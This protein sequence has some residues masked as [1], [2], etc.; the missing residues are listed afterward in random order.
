[1]SQPVIFLPTDILVH[2]IQHLVKAPKRSML[3]AM[4]CSQL[5]TQRMKMSF[6]RWS[7]WYSNVLRRM[8]DIRERLLQ[9]GPTV[10]PT[11]GSRKM[12]DT[13]PK[14]RE[15]DVGEAFAAVEKE[16][17]KHLLFIEQRYPSFAPTHVNSTAM[18][19]DPNMSC[20]ARQEQLLGP[21]QCVRSLM[22]KRNIGFDLCRELFSFIVFVRIGITWRLGS[23]FTVPTLPLSQKL[24][25]L[26]E[27]C[28][29]IEQ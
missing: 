24:D 16:L 2:L 25:Q 19:P 11:Y 3:M 20:R 13:E 9:M 29:W 23:R 7:C 26:R 15:N 8:V 4:T 5:K 6:S 1:M 14:Y 10:E 27:T 17:A 18:Y 21:R 12:R 22:E 28:C